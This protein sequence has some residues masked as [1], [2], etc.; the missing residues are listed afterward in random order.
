MKQIKLI[1]NSC[2]INELRL[3]LLFVYMIFIDLLSTSAISTLPK[4]S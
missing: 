1:I 2:K 4:R 3:Q